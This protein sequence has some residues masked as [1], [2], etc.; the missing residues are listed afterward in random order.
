MNDIVSL[1]DVVRFVSEGVT[2]VREQSLEGTACTSST[3][4]RL[5]TDFSVLRSL[6]QAG[7]LSSESCEYEAMGL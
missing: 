3:G 7:G 5:S 2:G 1:V 4:S 6:D